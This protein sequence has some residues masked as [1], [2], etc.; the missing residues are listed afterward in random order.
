M[1][2]PE[3]NHSITLSS[4]SVCTATN[5]PDERI[6]YPHSPPSLPLS[7][8]VSG[9]RDMPS[10]TDSSGSS[11]TN[12]LAHKTCSLTPGKDPETL[13]CSVKICQLLSR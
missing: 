9:C 5:P 12:W 13:S 3:S 2:T 7:V 10:L 11:K 6:G 8:T 1:A 4:I